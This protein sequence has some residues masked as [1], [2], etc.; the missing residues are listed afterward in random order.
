[1]RTL[2][3][4]P[5]AV[6]A[7][8][9]AACAGA[10]SQAPATGDTGADGELAGFATILAQGDGEPQLCLGGVAESYPPQC[11]GLTLVG[12]DWA[13][14]ADAETASGT[15]WGTGWAV[16]R[17][18]ADAGT[19]TLTRP[20][21]TDPPSGVSAP[22]PLPTEFPALCDDPFRGGDEAFDAGSAEGMAAQ[23]Q[24]TSTAAALDGY[25]GL[26]VSDG[27]GA[28]NVL[29]QGDA[30]AAHTA[31]RQVWPGWLCVSTS[32]GAAEADVLAAQE[33]L[34]QQLGPDVVLG[35]GGF[36]DGAVHVDVVVADDATRAAVLDAVEPWLTPEQVVLTAALVPVAG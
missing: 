9:L 4:V 25:V 10:P 16:G 18:D 24:L 8:L 1:M 34:H 13:D 22:E 23:E 14:V 20:V 29:V 11:S 7:A 27:S 15:T 6:A 30:E 33:A 28:F 19:F 26:Y 32:D 21:T 36:I 5:I 2:R 31:L 17:Y 35:S 12:L 3:W